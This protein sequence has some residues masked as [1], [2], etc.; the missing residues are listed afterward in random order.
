MKEENVAEKVFAISFLLY[1][2]FWLLHGSCEKCHDK[3][4]SELISDPK[5]IRSCRNEH[6]RQLSVL[7]SVCK[8]W[9]LIGIP[10]L[11]GDYTETES[12]L[13]LLCDVPC[14]RSWYEDYY[15]KQT[16]S[17]KE[18][19]CT[20]INELFLIFVSHLLFVFIK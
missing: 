13:S 10:Q 11:W 14:K 5:D 18:V 16:E 12:L 6:V 3:A 17:V 1:D 8:R 15:K 2:I 20:T 4:R 7:I 19:R 9:S